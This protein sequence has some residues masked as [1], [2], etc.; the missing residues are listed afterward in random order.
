MIRDLRHAIR[1][2]LQAKGWTTIVVVSLALTLGAWIIIPI[3]IGIAL[4][5]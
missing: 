3:L 1:I 5:T 2:L 4:A